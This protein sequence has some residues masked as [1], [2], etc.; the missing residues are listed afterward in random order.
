M[1]HIEL[2][3][4]RKDEILEYKMDKFLISNYE[5][6]QKAQ[7]NNMNFNLLIS[8]DGKTRTGK[9]TI[10]VQSACYFDDTFLD[11]WKSRIV[12]DWELLI[13][14][15]NKLQPGQAIIYDEAR[16]VLNSASSMTRYCQ[17]LLTFFSRVGSKNLYIFVVLPDFFDLPKSL[18]IVQSHCLINCYFRNGFQRGYF[19]FFNDNQ[20]KYLYVMG[21]KFLDYKAANPSFKGTFTKWFPID[22]NIYEAHKQAEFERINKKKEK[23][24]SSAQ[25]KYRKRIAIL[26]EWLKKDFKQTQKEI[27]KHLD[28]TPEEVSQFLKR[29][30]NK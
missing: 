10:A 8:G 14:T 4:K 26:M 13:S 29:E 1:S 18:A 16:D 25:I 28:I 11:N 2:T 5:H 3:T 24:M 19:D 9:T 7:R 6:F 12:Y 22:Y 30:N 23:P 21:K 20:K 15:S 17:K 27:A